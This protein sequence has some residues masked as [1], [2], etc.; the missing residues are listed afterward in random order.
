MNNPLLVS[1]L[2]IVPAFLILNE[3]F[4]LERASISS[5]RKIGDRTS[6]RSKLVELGHPKEADYEN[7]RY[8]EVIISSSLIFAIILFGIVKDV[9]ISTIFP[10]VI[11]G[12]SGSILLLER[13]L[14]N[15]VK[16]YR[17]GIEEEFPAIVE[18]LTLSI[19]AGES[20]LSAFQRISQRGSGALVIQLREVVNQ[21]SNGMPFEEALDSLGRRMYSLNIRRFID[22]IV[23]ALSRGA[24]L[25]DVL[26]SHAEEAQSLQRNRITALAAKTEMAMMIPVVFLILPISILFALWPSLSNLNVFVQS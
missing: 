6:V 3:D 13:N 2:F 19:S 23:I 14:A 7:F 17:E 9:R 10:L 12:F 5:I 25:V 24:P 22:S 26:Q 18:M 1:L 11:I 21:V 15:K 8:K 4:S 16:K 20:P